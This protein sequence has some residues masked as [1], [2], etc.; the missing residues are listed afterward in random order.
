MKR[1]V[2]TEAGVRFE[3]IAS[4]TPPYAVERRIREILSVHEGF[5]DLKHIAPNRSRMNGVGCL[6][7]ERPF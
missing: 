7:E 6:R 1:H 2:L 4:G 3:E 5:R